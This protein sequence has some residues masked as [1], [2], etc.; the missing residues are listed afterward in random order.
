MKVY[1]SENGY[2]Y[3]QYKNGENKR[4]SE[5]EYKKLFKNMKGGGLSKSETLKLI[6]KLNICS[7]N[8]IST[9][10]GSIDN[11]IYRFIAVPQG[12][13]YKYD[14]KNVIDLGTKK[15]IASGN[16]IILYIMGMGPCRGLIIYETDRIL[17]GH[18]DEIS[19]LSP[20]TLQ[21]IDES[22]SGDKE[23]INSIYYVMGMISFNCILNEK[24]P[25]CDISTEVLDIIQRKQLEEYVC[26]VED[27][28]YETFTSKFG[29]N[30]QMDEFI[31]FP[32]H[33]TI[34]NR[35]I[36]KEEKQ[37][38]EWQEKQLE[39]WDEECEECENIENKLI[40]NRKNSK[41]YQNS[42]SKCLSC[43][44]KIKSRG[45]GKFLCSRF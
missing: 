28:A 42:K 36:T 40:R 13:I 10:Y 30:W 21:T 41:K 31:T 17:M 11:I 14:G 4:I 24:C 7:I 18:L 32:I 44:F 15:N 9:I 45:K 6:N 12:H 35:F 16:N 19:M 34:T 38:E 39:E 37:S 23:K 20:L 33:P 3:K 43:N 8:D 1:K 22:L 25:L 26:I 29:Y 2:F 27:F 5:Q